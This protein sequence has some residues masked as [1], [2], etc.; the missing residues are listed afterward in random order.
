VA[1]RTA[2]VGGIAIISPSTR[3]PLAEVALPSISGVTLPKCRPAESVEEQDRRRDLNADLRGVEGAANANSELW[4]FADGL[5]SRP[6]QQA[7][8]LAAQHA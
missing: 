6:S 5:R 2:A 8:P 4:Q 1:G 3:E 7:T